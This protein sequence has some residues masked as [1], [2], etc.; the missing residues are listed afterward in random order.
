MKTTIE[1]NGNEVTFQRGQTTIVAGL[2]GYD[3]DPACHG[4]LEVIDNEGLLRTNELPPPEDTPIWV[5]TTND[6][7]G[8]FAYTLG[9]V[10]HWLD[11]GCPRAEVK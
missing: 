5:F 4:K 9:M 6:R 1:I 11:N 8:G 2:Y 7:G 10:Q 3:S